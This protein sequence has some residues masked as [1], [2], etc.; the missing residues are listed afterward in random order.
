MSPPL[1][2][3]QASGP[4]IVEVIGD[5]FIIIPRH[6]AA[7]RVLA[8]V[9]RAQACDAAGETGMA[10]IYASDARELARAVSTAGAYQHR[11]ESRDVLSD[12]QPA[13]AVI[14]RFLTH[15]FPRLA[16]VAAYLSAMAVVWCASLPR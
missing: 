5:R 1:P 2:R 3:F 16:V 10:R 14:A 9:A 12:F 7:E 15:D 6:E 8:W 13:P 11:G 4:D